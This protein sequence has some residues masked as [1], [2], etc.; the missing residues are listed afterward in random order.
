MIYDVLFDCYSA[1]KI[2]RSA[3]HRLDLYIGHRAEILA[4]L[5]PVSWL[6][7]SSISAATMRDHRV[8]LFSLMKKS[9]KVQR[10]SAFRTFSTSI[11]GKNFWLG[12]DVSFARVILLVFRVV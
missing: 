8:Q 3:D 12:A 7:E 9:E 1:H 10:M 11:S 2:S 5:N 6:V 4:V